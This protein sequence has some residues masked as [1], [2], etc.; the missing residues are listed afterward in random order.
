MSG[1]GGNEPLVDPSLVRARGLGRPG[2]H[3]GGVFHGVN[4]FSS[5][6]LS[7]RVAGTGVQ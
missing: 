1:L 6:M 4:A 7:V 3:L 5:R 2:V